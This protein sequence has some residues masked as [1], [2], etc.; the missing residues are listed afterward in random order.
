MSL[1]ET[2]FL[3]NFCI[4]SLILLFLFIKAVTGNPIDPAEAKG[5]ILKGIVYSFTGSMSPLKKETANKHWPTYLAGILYH[6]GIFLGFF[7]LF[8]NLTNIPL[9]STAYSLS[10]VLFIITIICGVAILLKRIF[11]KKLRYLSNPDDYASNVLVTGFL[12]IS[13][14]NLYAT[15]MKPF[16][17]Y[18]SALLFLYMPVGKLKHAAYFV[19][20]RVYLGIFYGIRGIW[21]LVKQK[22]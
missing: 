19:L 15:H 9:F 18:Y 17:F 6:S 4:S 14:L 16:L 20:A 2:V 3:I 22:K 21:P 13:V 12:I 1:S 10:Q 7:W 8:I 11:N 5:S